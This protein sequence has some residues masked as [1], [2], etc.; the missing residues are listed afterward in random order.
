MTRRACRPS[1]C[2]SRTVCR[3][4]PVRLRVISANPAAL[5]AQ[6]HTRGTIL[7]QPVDCRASTTAA[8]ESL[9]DLLAN[10][11]ATAPEED[12]GKVFVLVGAT[13]IEPVTSAV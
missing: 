4:S 8:R 7:A 13:G 12:S 11:L 9:G 6:R 3:I 2:C 1:G 5:L 10:L